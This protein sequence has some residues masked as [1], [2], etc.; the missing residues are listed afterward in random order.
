MAFSPTSTIL[1]APSLSRCEKVMSLPS[2]ALRPFSTSASQLSEGAHPVLARDSPAMSAGCRS[3]L[4]SRNPWR[5]NAE[6]CWEMLKCECNQTASIAAANQFE[7]RPGHQATHSGFGER[8]LLH[9]LP[10]S[11]F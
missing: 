7:D 8:V 2:V 9:H 1:A 11:A 4:I 5:R 6:C 10:V 3:E